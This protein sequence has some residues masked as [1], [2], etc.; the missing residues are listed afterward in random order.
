MHLLARPPLLLAGGILAR[1]PPLSPLSSAPPRKP[2][3]SPAAGAAGAASRDRAAVSRGTARRRRRAG[4]QRRDRHERRSGGGCRAAARARSPRAG[5]GA[6]Q[7]REPG[8]GR[9]GRGAAGAGAGRHAPLSRQGAE[10]RGRHRAAGRREPEHRPRLRGAQPVARAEARA[11]RGARARTVGRHVDLHAAADAAAAVG[12]RDRIRRSCRSTAATPASARRSSAS[13]SARAARTSGSATT[14]R[15]CSPPARRTPS[16]STSRTSTAGRPPPGSPSRDELDRIYPN[17]SKRLA[18]DFY[19]QPQVYRH[20]GQA[21]SLPAGEFTVTATP[22]PGI[23]SADETLLGRRRIRA[24]LPAAALDRSVA[25]RLVFR[26][27]PHPLV[28]LLALRE[29]DRGRQ[30]GRHV[31][32][33]RRRS[34]QPRVG[35]DLGAVV[36]LPEAVLQRRRSSAVD[37]VPADALR[38]RGLRLSVE[39]RRPPRAARPEGPGLSRHEAARGLADVDAADPEVGA[40]AG[41]GRRLRAFG[42]GAR[43]Q[44]QRAPELRHARLRRHRRQRVHRRR[45]PSRRPSISSPPGTRRTSGS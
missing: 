14:S 9:A 29:P 40:G 21:I 7:P 18:P 37:A 45:H 25:V 42:V 2:G 43:G 28:R 15:C 33:D 23:H 39:P 5:H 3:P 16:G 4:A 26:R 31:A 20:D 6:H 12:T 13:T 30:A 36:L 10:R 11:D 32:A 22:R 38:P 34:A 19:F 41:R 44:E 24:D 1:R 8:A 27:S 17:I 35:A